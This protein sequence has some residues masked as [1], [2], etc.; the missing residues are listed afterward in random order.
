MKPIQLTSAQTKTWLEGKSGERSALLE[1]VAVGGLISD[2]PDLIRHAVSNDPENPKLTYI[3]AT[4]EAFSA[5]EQLEH[6]KQFYINAPENGLAGFI[7]AARLFESGDP[8]AAIRIL[9]ASRDRHLIDD[10]SL[11]RQLLMEEAY[12]ATGASAIQAKLQANFYST[13]PYLGDLLAFAGELDDLADTMPKQEAAK[14]RGHTA[15]MGVR[16]KKS[17]EAGT[18]IDQLGG[19]AIE[20]RALD[21]L[22]EEDVS[23]YENLTIPQAREALATQ[24]AEIQE[25]IKLIKLDSLAKNNPQL[26]GEFVDKIRE[27]GE[28]EALKWFQKESQP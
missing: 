19:L 25:T 3:G 28:L 27:M 1:S 9:R 7:Y 24:K 8:T 10:F 5:E 12:Q 20:A 15:S 23:P 13:K 2:D 26:L 16:L 14:L 4:N 18:I 6:S 21:G 17:A 22:G 11:D